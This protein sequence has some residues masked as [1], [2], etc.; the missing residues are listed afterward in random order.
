MKLED[1][2]VIITGAARGIGRAMARRFSAEKPRAL[3]LADRDLEG[4]SAVAAELGAFASAVQ[5]DVAFEAEVRALIA[6]AR[7]RF[8]RIDLF[9]ANAGVGS[10]MGIEAP[11]AEWRRVLDINLMSHV[12][13]ARALLP[14]PT[15]LLVTA[16]A[17][18]LLAMV[19]D[20]SYTV[21]KHGAVALAEWLAITYGD[22]GLQVSCLCPQFVN[23]DLL[24]GALQTAGGA[25]AIAKSGLVLEP[26]Q[27]ADVVVAGLE[28]ERFLILPHAEVATFE[29]KKAADRDRW[30]RAMRKVRDG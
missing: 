26:E 12:W 14:G 29:Q 18:G 10:S 21:S 28:A 8:G 1:K 19:G 6:G 9:C 27:V 7:E 11:D 23:T 15:Y 16:S 17:A 30:I 5:C 24:A 13:A 2:V 3:V 22:R 25:S 4:V 20:A